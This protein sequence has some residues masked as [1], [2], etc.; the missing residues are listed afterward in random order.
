M[1]RRPQRRRSHFSRSQRTTIVTAI[2][3]FVGLVTVLQLWLFVAS[4]NAFMGGDE[5]ILLPAA[6][7]SLACLGLNFGLLFYTYE[8]SK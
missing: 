4:M 3:C 8:L 5:Q 7:V 6:L 1:I 2:L